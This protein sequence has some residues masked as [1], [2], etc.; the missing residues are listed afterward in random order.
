MTPQ[1]DQELQLLY[2]LYKDV[3]QVTSWVKKLFALQNLFLAS[4]A[5]EKQPRYFVV[6]A[7]K[8]KKFELTVQQSQKYDYPSPVESPLLEKLAVVEQ[9]EKKEMKENKKVLFRQFSLVSKGN[10]I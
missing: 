5:E 2:Q 8:N 3:I 1:G 10:E 7:D 9:Y 6:N 4:M